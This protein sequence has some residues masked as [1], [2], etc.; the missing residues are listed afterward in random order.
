M[1]ISGSHVCYNCDN[2][3]DWEAESKV[4]IS[5]IPGSKS[6]GFAVVGK[7]E[8]EVIIKCP[9]CHIWNKFGYK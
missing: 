9:K 8:Y 6:G 4:P 5:M 2:R 3:F 7:G 1:K